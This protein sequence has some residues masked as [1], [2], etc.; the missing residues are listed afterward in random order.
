MCIPIA[1]VAER[2]TIALDLYIFFE[3]VGG[4][5]ASPCIADSVAGDI[6]TGGGDAGVLGCGKENGGGIDGIAYILGSNR[7]PW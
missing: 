6:D 2:D 7:K 4:V 3:P 1:V 5:N